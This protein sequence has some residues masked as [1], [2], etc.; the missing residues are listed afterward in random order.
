M[1]HKTELKIQ[2]ENLDI[3]DILIL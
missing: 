1:Q 3:L 2:F